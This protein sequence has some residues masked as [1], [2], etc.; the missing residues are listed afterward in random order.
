MPFDFSA[1]SRVANTVYQCE[2]PAPVM[3]R[4]VP[5]SRKPPPPAGS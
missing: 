4:L 2:T 1:G 3:K 5:E